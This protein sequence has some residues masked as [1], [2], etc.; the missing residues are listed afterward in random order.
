MRGIYAVEDAT[1]TPSTPSTRRRER[2]E[3]NNAKTT[4][5]QHKNNA[6]EGFEV[7]RKS[8]DVK[9]DA[10]SLAKAAAVVYY[11]SVIYHRKVPAT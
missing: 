11:S 6:G 10:S 5:K 8:G 2:I 9:I 7:L 4:Q 1:E 3:A